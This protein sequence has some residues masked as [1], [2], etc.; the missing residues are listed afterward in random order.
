MVKIQ[1]FYLLFRPPIRQSTTLDLN[2]Y[3]DEEKNA[4]S[5]A[6]YEPK[7]TEEDEK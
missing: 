7:Y 4:F 5:S 1:Y 2:Y 3:N 6:Q